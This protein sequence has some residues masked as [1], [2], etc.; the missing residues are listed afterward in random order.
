[1]NTVATN[2]EHIKCAIPPQ[3][4]LVAVSKFHRAELINE[5]YI[6]GQQDF[7][8]SRP[9]ELAQ[10]IKALPKD[11]IWHFI[12]R[13]QTN[14]IKMV[15][16]YAHLI[17][18]IDSVKL[19]QAVQNY[20]KKNNLTTNVLLQIHVA[21]EEAKSGFAP[22][23]LLDFIKSGNLQTYGNINFRGL[24]AMASNTNNVEQVRSEFRMVKQLHEQ[25]KP[26]FPTPPLFTEI[27]MGMSGDYLIAI[28]EGA[29]LVRIGTAIF[30]NRQ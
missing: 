17:H 23:E 29:T 21:Q 7:G 14:K 4:R 25:A 8:E 16:P 6:A 2:L 1:M 22:D 28:E 10:K 3:V 15:V 24:M 11:I 27:S 20:C 13:L 30:G 12:G 19:L 26:L 5:A 9:Q 18:S